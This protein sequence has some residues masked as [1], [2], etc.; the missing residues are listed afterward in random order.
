MSIC[1]DSSFPCSLHQVYIWWQI[2]RTTTLTTLSPHQHALCRSYMLLTQEYGSWRYFHLPLSLCPPPPTPEKTVG[3]LSLFPLPHHSQLLGCTEM[4]QYTF[5]REL[6][7][8]T[9][10][11]Y[12]SVLAEQAYYTTPD[13]LTLFFY[14]SLYT[15]MYI[16]ITHHCS[17]SLPSSSSPPLQSLS[18]SLFLIQWAS[19]ASHFSDGP[20][21]YMHL[22]KDVF[23][24][25]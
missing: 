25:I 11:L 10:P 18:L 14:I 21:G 4:V 13:S 24:R 5:S 19:L 3:A 17:P 23:G 7:G 8:V 16:F 6:C 9:C 22:G 20:Y 15:H 12:S 2:V 1:A